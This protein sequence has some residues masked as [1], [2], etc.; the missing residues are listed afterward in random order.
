MN[1]A[2]AHLMADGLVSGVLRR[3]EEASDDAA[4]LI[5]A[6]LDLCTLGRIAQAN[7]YWSKQSLANSLWSSLHAARCDGK[8]YRGLNSPREGPPHKEVLRDTLQDSTRTWLSEKE[9]LSFAWSFRFKASAGPTWAE[10]DPWWQGGEAAQVRFHADGSATFTGFHAFDDNPPSFSWRFERRTS[11]LRGPR[12]SFVRLLVGGR[13]VPT[14]VVSR[15]HNWGFIMQSCWAVY[16]SWP[17]P[18]KAAGD[19]TLT[20][21]A[22]GFTVDDQAREAEQYNFG[23]N[24]SD[25]DDD[26]DGEDGGEDEAGGGGGYA[27][28]PTEAPPA[29]QEATLLGGA[30]RSDDDAESGALAAGVRATVAGLQARADLNGR[31]VR[32]LQWVDARARWA[33]SVV[34]SDERIL[35]RPQNLVAAAVAAEIEAI[36]DGLRASQLGEGAGSSAAGSSS[37]AA[38][39]PEE[40]L[41]ESWARM[42]RSLAAGTAERLG[43]AYDI[44]VTRE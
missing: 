28:A 37:A 30:A 1:A 3:I 38:A 26:E 41:E 39:E 36:E 16:T 18:R 40:T 20:D 8:V 33:V 25:E 14:Y 10:I 22:L 21:E 5:L 43:V 7:K 35:V 29:E 23:A 17:M 19:A 31:E 44:G 6:Q 2:S 42:Q 11:G 13:P 4:L 32:V 12:G 34:G 27:V 24:S 15:H 9:L